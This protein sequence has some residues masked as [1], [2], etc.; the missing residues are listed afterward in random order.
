MPPVLGAKA[1]GGKLDV[2]MRQEVV[3]RGQLLVDFLVTHSCP[4]SGAC[5]G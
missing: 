2:A 5:L 3:R 1:W 4:L